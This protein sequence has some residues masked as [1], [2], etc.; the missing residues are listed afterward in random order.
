MATLAFG[1][2]LPTAVKA[3]GETGK[4]DVTSKGKIKFTQDDTVNPPNV[5]P[6]EGGEE[7]EEPTQNPAKLPLKIVSVTDLDFDT[8]KIVANDLDKKFNATAF[9]TK[10]KGENPKD[11]ILPHFVRFQDIRSDGENNHYTVS[12]KL[13]KQFSD[14]NKTLT[15]ASI[16]YKNLSLVSGT[17]NA[18]LPDTKDGALVNTFT[19]TE[20]GGPETVFTNKQDGKGFGVFEIVFGDIKKPIENASDYENIVLTV[21]GDNVIKQ[22]TIKQKLLGQSLK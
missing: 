15:G 7:I 14:G 20:K 12:A 13:T 22:E 6:G 11:V 2:L 9:K 19:L 16:E 17:N 5:G 3:E 10:T 8:H 4:P 18:T 21:P 1:M